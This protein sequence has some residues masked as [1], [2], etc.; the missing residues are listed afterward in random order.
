MVD[1]LM[2]S[3]ALLYIYTS[4]PFS[5]SHLIFV[6]YKEW[7]KLYRFCSHVNILKSPTNVPE[8]CHSK[9]YY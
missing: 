9:K 4:G 7:K 1:Y 6:L 8:I 3:L 5:T 2:H